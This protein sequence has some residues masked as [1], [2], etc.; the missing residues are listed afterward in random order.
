MSNNANKE[1]G[2]RIQ[3]TFIIAGDTFCNINN[4][5]IGGHKWKLNLNN[6]SRLFKKGYG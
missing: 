4:S 3:Y 2:H 1:R 6:I 5:T